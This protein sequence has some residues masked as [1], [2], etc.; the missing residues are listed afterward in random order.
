[1]A[2]PTGSLIP[3]DELEFVETWIRYFAIQARTKKLKDHQV[4]GWENEI[5]N[6]FLVSTRSEALRKISVFAYPRELGDLVY[7][8]IPDIVKRN[9]KPKKEVGYL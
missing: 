3:L 6:L 7:S 9:L 5:T 8:Q 2:S 4:T 1:M